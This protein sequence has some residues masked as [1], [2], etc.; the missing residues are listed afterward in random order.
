MLFYIV[1]L[2]NQ[3]KC[4]V[5]TASRGSHTVQ[6][7]TWREQRP[8]HRQQDAL[9]LFLTSTER[10]RTAQKLLVQPEQKGDTGKRFLTVLRNC[11]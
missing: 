11:G 1:A 9:C 7:S 6:G 2:G 3:H 5:K 4:H 10:V 8:W